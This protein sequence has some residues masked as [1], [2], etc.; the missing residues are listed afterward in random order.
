MVTVMGVEFSERKWKKAIKSNKGLFK[1][2]SK[3][4]AM[5]VGPTLTENFGMEGYG[6]SMEITANLPHCTEEQNKLFQNLMAA[7][8]IDKATEYVFTITNVDIVWKKKIDLIEGLLS[9]VEKEEEELLDEETIIRRAESMRER[10][11]DPEL[12]RY[13]GE[14]FRAIRED[15]GNLE[16]FKRDIDKAESHLHAVEEKLREH[17]V[18]LKRH[19]KFL[20]E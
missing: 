9:H 20:F 14:D 10:L 7:G 17:L 13:F 3:M 18:L 19:Y 12:E 5:V 16:K 2:S 1:R 6:A 15:I 4:P 11:I 8:D